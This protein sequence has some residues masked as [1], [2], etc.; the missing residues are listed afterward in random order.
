MS[1]ELIQEAEKYLAL[2]EDEGD[3]WFGRSI[4]MIAALVDRVK[5][6]EKELGHAKING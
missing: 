1:Q 3:G 6:L 5:E 2:L 4:G